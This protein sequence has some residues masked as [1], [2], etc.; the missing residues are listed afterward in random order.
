MLYKRTNAPRGWR[1][2]T[3]SCRCG[4]SAR[5]GQ[6]NAS[7]RCPHPRDNFNHDCRRDGPLVLSTCDRGMLSIC[8]RH[9]S[10]VASGRAQDAKPGVWCTRRPRAAPRDSHAGWRRCTFPWARAL[11]I[12]GA[13]Y[14]RAVYTIRRTAQGAASGDCRMRR[15]RGRHHA[16]NALRT[17]EDDVPGEHSGHDARQRRRCPEQRPRSGVCICCGLSHEWGSYRRAGSIHLSLTGALCAPRAGKVVCGVRANGVASLWSGYGATLARDIPYVVVYWTTYDALRRLLFVDADPD[18][19]MA[20]SFISGAIAG[21]LAATLVTP[22]DVVK[23]RV[24]VSG[25]QSTLKVIKGLA[26][27]GPGAFFQGLSA[28]LIRT[29][30][31][32]GI[33]LCSFEALKLKMAQLN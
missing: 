3:P 21:T 24:Q 28:R 32:A 23:T 1:T 25:T 22:A 4:S 15:R 27:R 13:R 33:T 26:R 20:K 10:D 30:I 7:P 11:T 18:T 2:P 14:G 5:P 17:Y 6:L 29:P 16:E 9:G 19:R 12:N 31:Y 8:R